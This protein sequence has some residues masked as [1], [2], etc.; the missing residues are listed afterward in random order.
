V[1]ISSYGLKIRLSKRELALQTR[2]I[3]LD[4][5]TSS[6]F[7]LDFA[8]INKNCYVQKKAQFERIAPSGITNLF[9][10]EAA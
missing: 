2:T 3:E 6:G 7:K 5:F 1:L 4:T 9:I 8:N 10:N